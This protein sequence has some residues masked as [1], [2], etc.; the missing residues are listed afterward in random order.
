M[1]V[2]I[3]GVVVVGGGAAGLNAALVLG[4]AR[5]RVAVVDAGAPRN[6]P[7]A[8][9]QGFLSR[10]GMSP[11]DLLPAGRVEVTGYGVAL[12]E[13]QVVG[14]D[15]GFIVRLAGGR[16]LTARLRAAATRRQAQSIPRLAW[17]SLPPQ[18]GHGYTRDARPRGSASSAARASLSAV[19][20]TNARSLRWTRLAGMGNLPQ[21]LDR[22]VMSVPPFSGSSVTSAR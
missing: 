18:S 19:S 7:A 9:M 17:R 22:Q 4:R 14:I 21:R 3:Y 11:A 12:L 6:A 1:E 15:D 5:R 13:D 20:A 16:V 10:D 2:P 8:H